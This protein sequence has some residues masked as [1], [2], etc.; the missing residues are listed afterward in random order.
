SKH[1]GDKRATLKDPPPRQL[2]VS[3][4]L[5]VLTKDLSS[6][7]TGFFLRSSRSVMVLLS[8]DVS[9]CASSALTPSGRPSS[10][11]STRSPLVKVIPPGSS[12]R[13]TF[14]KRGRVNRSIVSSTSSQVTHRLPIF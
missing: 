10:V 12:P 5:E 3:F 9:F 14:S 11:A 4:D 13:T 7:I 8:S 1:D 2:T 6:L